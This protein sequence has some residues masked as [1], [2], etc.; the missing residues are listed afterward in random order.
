MNLK[1]LSTKVT[2][3]HPCAGSAPLDVSAVLASTASKMALAASSSSSLILSLSSL[4]PSS[5]GNRAGIEARMVVEV[6]GGAEVV[7]V[8]VEA[9]GVLVLLEPPRP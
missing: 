3:L 5:L 8:V 9:V 6:G 4:G 1:I 2:D 7:V